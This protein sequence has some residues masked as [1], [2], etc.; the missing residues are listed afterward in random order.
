MKEEIKKKKE[1]K[2]PEMYSLKLLLE[3]GLKAEIEIPEG[4]Y[5]EGYKNLVKCIKIDDFFDAEVYGGSIE[6]EGE[7]VNSLNCKKVIALN[8]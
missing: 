5:D 6:I 4:S 3:N 2:E 8:Y 1:E 7:Y